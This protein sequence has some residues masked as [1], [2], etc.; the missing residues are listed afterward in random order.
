MNSF[1]P[2]VGGKGKLLWI[3]NKL[4]PDRYTRFIDVF[5]GSGTVTMCRP[6]Q[7]GCMEVYNDFNGNLTNLFCCVKNRPMALLAELGF[8]PLN[9]RDDFNVL[10]KFF[11]KGE[12]TD[13]YLQEEMDLTEVYLKPP[14]AEAIR[15]L[16]LE[17]APRGSIRRAA[18]FFKLIRYSFSGGAKSFGGKPCDIRRFFHL[19]WECS[20]RLANVIVENKDFEEVIRQY[21]R[22]GAVIYCDPPYYKAESCYEV[23]F[24]PEDHQRLHD[25]LVTC[26]GCFIVSYEVQKEYYTDK[27]MSNPVWTMAG[28]FADK[29]IT[30][31]SVK[32]R[33]DFMRMIR[34]CRQRKIDVVLTKSVSRFARNTVDCLYYTRALKELGIAVIFEKENINSLEEDSELRITLS[35][36]FAQSESESI[37]ANVT[38]GK[39]RAMESGKA[40]IQYKYLYGYRRGADDKPEIIPEEAEVVRWIYERY[41]A[42]ASTRMLRDE[43]HEQG[44]IYSEKSPQWTLPHIKSILR[45]EKYCGDVLMQKT[46]QQDVINRKVI[47]NTGQL[48]MYLIE[49]HHEG[50]VSREKYNAVQAEMARRKAAKSPSKRASTG[51]AAYTSRYALS[52]RLVCGECGTLY[53]RCTWT[54]PD[55]KRVVWRCVSRLDYGKKYCHSSPTLDEAPLQQAIIA[56]LN[57]VLPDLDGRI[58]QIT[59]ALEAEVIPFPGSGMSLGDIDRRLAELEAQFQRLLEK[60]ADDPIAYGDQFK[61]ILDEQTALKELRASILA[62]NKE[63]AEA[64]RRI[65]D[66]AGMLENAVPHIA[67]WDESA[68][69]QLVAQV[70]VLSKNEISVTLKSGIEIRQ[71]ISD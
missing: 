50:I 63:H 69:R 31:T 9:T 48:P 55:G 39:R 64:D 42:G 44:V 38:W 6:I 68:I 4:M 28:V 49:N 71:G 40:T 26:E 61:E 23:E 67:E 41:L 24:P 32:K 70:K 37:S 34:H 20:R 11:S 60:A 57:T 5:G 36:A 30:G 17:R 51:L 1:I 52:D 65:R 47:K 58:R 59:E 14:D 35:G 45:N 21:D 46:F 16:M 29:G 33:E 18:D 2:W 54:R 62:E 53:R 25:V 7:R 10:Y 56:A 22:A 27:I 8:L 13:D 15:A 12:F 43:L 3:I 19:I 66:A